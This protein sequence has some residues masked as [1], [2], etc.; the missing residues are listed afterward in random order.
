MKNCG[1]CENSEG[2]TENMMEAYYTHGFPKNEEPSSRFTQPITCPSCD[3]QKN[4]RDGF[5]KTDTGN[6]QRWLCRRCGFRFSS[7]SEL[8]NKKGNQQTLRR[9]VCV[10][11]GAMKNLATVESQGSGHAGATATAN[12]KGKIVEFLWYLKKQGYTETTTRTYVS[13]MR[14]LLK[15][16]HCSFECRDQPGKSR[17]TS[18]LRSC[19]SSQQKTR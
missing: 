6:I 15:H 14:M 8:K 13:I 7:D 18:R 3:S 4:W 19:P 17:D 11:D 16:I 1:K 2:E 9:R 5:R 12:A 10:A